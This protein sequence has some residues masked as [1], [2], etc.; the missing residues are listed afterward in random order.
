MK[1]VV[2][3]LGEKIKEKIEKKKKRSLAAHAV[4]HRLQ[5]ELF[6]DTNHSIS[7]TEGMQEPPAGRMQHG[8]A[9]TIGFP[10]SV[11]AVPKPAVM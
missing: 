3:S 4:I 11:V 2:T 8:G 6:T 9:G 10:A 5:R 7:G 1:G